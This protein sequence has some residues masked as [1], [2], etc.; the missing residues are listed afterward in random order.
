MPLETDLYTSADVRAMDATAIHALGGS[1]FDLMQRAAAAAWAHLRARWPQAARIGLLCGPGNNGGDGYLMGVCART[2]GLDVT[3]MALTPESLGEA[4]RARQ[5][6]LA[7]GGKIT[8]ATPQMSLPAVD[9]WVDALFGSGFNRVASGLAAHL[10][11]AV[12][13]T[14]RP[15]LALDV[16]SGLDADRGVITGPCVRAALTVCLVAWKRGLFTHHAGE[17]CGERVLAGLDL[18]AAA[19]ASRAP[20]AELLHAHSL[21]PRRRASHKGDFGHVLV[22]GGEAGFGGAVR[23]AGE[24]ALRTG[25]GLVSVATRAVHVAPL[26]AARPELMLHAVESAADVLPALARAGVLLSGPG[27]GQGAWGRVLFD[28]TLDAQ[29]PLVLDADGLNWLAQTPRAFSGQPVVLTPHPGEAARLL[30]CDVKTVQQDR[31]AA[32][33]ELAQAYAATVVLKGAGTLIATPDGRVRVCPWGNP[34]MAS[35]GMGDVLSGI[36]AGLLAQGL[37]PFAAACVGVGVHARA[38]DLAARV[39]ERGLLAADLFSYLRELLN[40]PT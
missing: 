39:G 32:V 17:A 6:F 34:G 38:G 4:A 7:A 2:A 27:L 36:I 18:P 13:T 22:L 30:G 33:R 8:V 10:I 19:L 40:D 26:L 5:A 12:N 11:E 1:G 24:A 9:V 16:P 20:D 28:L 15:V 21:P 37:S 3:A 25:A 35:G 23:L 29:R 31:F 14:A